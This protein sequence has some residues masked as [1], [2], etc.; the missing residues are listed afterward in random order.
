MLASVTDLDSLL[1]FAKP[2]DFGCLVW[3]RNKNLKG[4]GR[5]KFEGKMW[6]AH[7]LALYFATG[8][9][10]EQ[11]MHSCD[12]R[13]CVNPE[14]LSWGTNADNSADKVAKG[15]QAKTLNDHQVREIRKI[16]NNNIKPNQYELASAFGV[17]QA[18]IS[19]IVKGKVRQNV[20]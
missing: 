20:I 12:N 11:A 6:R 2:G 4:Y 3:Q 16:W 8:V 18:Q 5:Q 19:K 13:A 9:L 10:G 17:S 15:R 14:H 7:R 1:S